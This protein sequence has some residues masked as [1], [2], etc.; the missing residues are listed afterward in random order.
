MFYIVNPLT[1]DWSSLPSFAILRIKSHVGLLHQPF[2]WLFL[3]EG[4]FT[5]LIGVISFFKLPASA[6]HTKTWYRKNGWCTDR[7]EKIFINRVLKDDP[8][9]GDMN[10][11]KPVSPKQLLSSLLDYELLP[12]YIVRFLGDIGKAPVK[13]YMTL[14]LRKLG[15]STF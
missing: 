2:R 14:T 4:A 9:K 5:L 3:V 1:S 11:R 6:A 12:I 13:N 10:N 15:F 7:E 8:S